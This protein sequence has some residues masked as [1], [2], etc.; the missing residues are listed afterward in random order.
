MV[1]LRIGASLVSNS[2]TAAAVS[3]HKHTHRHD[4][5]HAILHTHKP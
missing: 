2:P 1:M 3:G 5:V 4:N